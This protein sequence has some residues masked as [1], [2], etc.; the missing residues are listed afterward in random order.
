MLLLVPGFDK[1]SDKL[2]EGKSKLSSLSF[3]G[4]MTVL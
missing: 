2:N 4:V 1:I 3:T